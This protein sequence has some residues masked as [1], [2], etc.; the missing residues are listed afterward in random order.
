MRILKTII[1]CALFM[2]TTATWAQQPSEN[3]SVKV[4]LLNEI[5]VTASQIS[6]NAPVTLQTIRANEISKYLGTKTYPEIMRNIAGVYATSESG[7]YGDAKI[8]IRG[9]KQENFTV[10]LNGVPLSGFRSGSMFWNN[11]LGLTDA[12]YR[13]Q[14][15]KGVGGSMLAANSMGGTINIV[16]KPAAQNTGGEAITS[17]TDYGLNNFRISLATGE[18]KNGW[19][20]SFVGSR[21][22]G[23]GYVDGTEVDSWG[24]FFNIQKIINHQHSLLF[25]L[26][27]SPERHGQRS[28]KLSNDE[29]KT[30]GLKYNKNWGEHNGKI[31]NVSENFYHKPYFSATH[32]F[33]ISD[34]MFLSNTLYFSIGNG[35]GKWSESTSKKITSYLNTCGQIDWQSVISDNVNNT[36]EI[37][38]PD[39][40]KMN[41][42]SK[43]IQSDYFAG[44]SWLGLKTSFDI[45]FSELLKLSSGLHYQYFY[46][47]QNE[48]ITDLLGGQFWYENYGKN[49]LAGFANREPMK[50]V[51]DYIRLNNGDRDNH[52][53]L[54]SQ[55]DYTTNCVHAFVGAMFMT[56]VYQHWDKYNYVRDY[57]SPCVTSSGGNVKAGVSLQFAPHQN[58]Y[59][60]GG[61]YSRMPY[62]SV[63]FAS[64]TNDVTDNVTNEKNYITEIGYKFAN[65]T[66]HL[67]INGYYN[68]W[69][70]KALMSDPYKPLDE[71]QVRYMITGL[72][73]QHTGL[74]LNY[75]QRMTNWLTVS[76]FASIGNWRWKNNVNATIY[77]PYTS[78]P[79]DTLQVFTDGLYV[80]DAPQ[81]QFGIAANVK[82]FN[83]LEVR[84]ECRYNARMFANFDPAKR[85][86]AA[87]RSQSYRIPSS[88]VADVHINFPFVISNLNANLF[89][90]CNNVFNAYFIERGDDG[91]NHDL[92][93]F[94]G[95]WSSGRNVQ[96]GLR[97]KF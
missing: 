36:D 79:I 34:K 38:L 51:G 15:Q 1:F 19:S 4:E 83:T 95:F 58:I 35:G 82:I 44:H 94:R 33:N 76:A 32:F 88:F 84:A 71:N 26:L 11:W 53:S 52:L 23:N 29:V 50:K 12:T 64:N 80:G 31:N 16:T 57:Y 14:V 8:N 86:N 97:I 13:I 41:G 69:K 61:F 91:A 48:K 5:I 9:F 2:F 6:D 45:K 60:N 89:F 43:N 22:W 18:L 74:E 67:T 27:G 62:N 49:S 55:L 21:T 7:S 65:Q 42:Y 96:A 24:Y 63:Y 59:I 75:D 17:I 3:D 77:D 68:Y 20:L 47:W 81:T 78:L 93:S 85:T 72:D 73:A 92:A 28:Q 87:D 56:A 40:R 66:T 54:Y 25:T 70:N 39:G 37:T 90:D 30:Y 46:S 10:M